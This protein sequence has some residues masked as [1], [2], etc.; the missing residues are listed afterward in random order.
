MNVCA[1]VGCESVCFVYV[2]VHVRSCVYE[3][4]VKRPAVK[5]SN[6]CLCVHDLGV[7]PSVLG[8][9]G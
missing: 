4:M 3:C 7:L 6:H 5:E 8:D 1:Q 2:F 9:W